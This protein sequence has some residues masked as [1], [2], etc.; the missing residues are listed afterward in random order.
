[1][2][3]IAA[4]AAAVQPLLT[5][6]ADRAGRESGFVRRRRTLTGSRFVQTVVCG[7]LAKPDASLS[8]LAQTGAA[9][10]IRISPQGLAQRCTAEAADCLRRVLGTAMTRLLAAAPVAVPLLRRFPGVYLYDSTVIRLPDELAA[11]WP[12][13]GGRVAANSQAALK[14]QVRW[15]LATGELALVAIQPGRVPDRAAAALADP[16]PAGALRLTDLGYVTLALLATL[17]AQRVLVLSRLPALPVVYD[18]AGRRHTHAGAFLAAR[19]AAVVDVPIR[20]GAAAQVPCRLVAV[21]VAAQTA[22]RR[23]RA[24]RRAAKREG[25]TPSPATL[26][27]ADWDAFLTTAPADLLS[28]DEVLALVGARWQVELLFKLWKQHGRVD[29]WRSRQPWRILCEVYAKL[30][31]MLLQH[32]CLLLGGWQDPRRSLVKA[33]AVVRQHAHALARARGNRAALRQVLAALTEEL[34]HA[35]RVTTRRRRPTTAHRLLAFGS[36]PAPTRKIA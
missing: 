15:E 8:E 36:P 20:L 7:W 2:V 35:G 21:R 10:G 13:C 18:A 29:D 32:W 34:P 26:A 12:G 24:L 11:R 33:A 17:A 9:V 23:R 3:S 19:R 14:V 25:R 1:M 16:L 28:V 30:L 31:A 5:E 27:L 4:V 22:N 6:V